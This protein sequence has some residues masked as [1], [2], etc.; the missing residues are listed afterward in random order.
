MASHTPETPPTCVSHK[1]AAQKGPNPTVPNA[2]EA[3]EFMNTVSAWNSVLMK[4]NN[5]MLGGFAHLH[6]ARIG[7]SVFPG[8]R[9][10]VQT[11]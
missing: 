5:T 10:E 7:K 9:V 4:I 6:I 1:P 3:P 2:D 11:A 8:L